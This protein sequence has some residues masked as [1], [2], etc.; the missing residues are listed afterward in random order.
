[1]QLTGLLVLAYSKCI[2]QNVQFI[3]TLQATVHFKIK[4]T[5]KTLGKNPLNFY[6]CVLATP[7]PHMYINILPFRSYERTVYI[8]TKHVSWTIVK[9]HT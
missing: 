1:M 6:R 5:T 2:L 3:A 4:I 7:G 9:Y 8:G